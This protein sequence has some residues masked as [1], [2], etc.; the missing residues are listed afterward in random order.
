MK[1]PSITIDRLLVEL[2]AVGLGEHLH[3]VA[4]GDVLLTA[5]G[6]LD[7]LE[8]ERILDAHDLGLCRIAQEGVR[9]RHFD[10]ILV[11]VGIKRHRTHEK[12]FRRDDI[13]VG[14]REVD[15]VH[16]V[17]AHDIGHAR[18]GGVSAPRRWCRHDCPSPGR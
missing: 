17:I 11:A 6:A 10:G 2:P 16:E 1:D 4:P 12:G 14:R 9:Q 8:H 13:R 15:L 7:F 3:V 5:D 18:A